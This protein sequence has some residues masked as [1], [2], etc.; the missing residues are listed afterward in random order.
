MSVDIVMPFLAETMDEGTIAVWLKQVGDRVEFGDD[1]VEI[2]TDKLTTV[3]QSD[4]AGVLLEILAQPGETVPCGQA[5][6]RVG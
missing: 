6:A 2:E 4:A 3:Y 5:I 1:L